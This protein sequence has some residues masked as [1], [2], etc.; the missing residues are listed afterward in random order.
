MKNRSTITARRKR[1]GVF[2][3]LPAVGFFLV[4]YVV[5]LVSVLITSL[6]RWSFSGPRTFVGLANFGSMG[7]GSAFAHAVERTLYF[8][9]GSGFLTL[10][11]AFVLALLLDGGLRG[12]RRLRPVFRGLRLLYFAPSIVSFSVVAL[13]FS[14]M[15]RPLG[16]ITILGEDLLGLDL[17]WQSSY[18]LAMP[19]VIVTWVWY[20]VGFYVLI[21]LAAISVLPRDY[22]EA[23]QLDGASPLRVLLHIKIPL[24][25]PVILLAAVL[26]LSED[27]RSFSPAYLLTGG[28]PGRET[29]VLT[30]RIYRDAFEQ[31]R[32]GHA[33]AESVGMLGILLMFTL[34]Y[35]RLLRRETEY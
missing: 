10:A 28:G 22:V 16:I 12:D 3:V 29:T 21:F 18:A 11:I 14:Y 9:A 15:F 26:K 20:R 25:N 19:S 35:F 4:F 23:A 8:A 6:T 17:P 33:S 1:T 7:L 31:L 30:L 34:A 24:M 32:V 2:F 5:P 27:F 13:L